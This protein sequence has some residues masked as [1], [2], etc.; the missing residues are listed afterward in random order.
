MRDLRSKE[1]MGSRERVG[2]REHVL[3]YWIENKRQ[4]CAGTIWLPV[5]MA[6]NKATLRSHSEELQK[7]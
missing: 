6:D 1:K 3:K 7:K 5:N 2:K 4:A